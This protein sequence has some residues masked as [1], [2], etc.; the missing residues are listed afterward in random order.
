MVHMCG[1]FFHYTFIKVFT[2]SSHFYHHKCD[3]ICCCLQIPYASNTVGYILICSVN[4]QN[5]TRIIITFYDCLR[6]IYAH[7]QRMRG[8]RMKKEDPC[9]CNVSIILNRKT[10][11]PTRAECGVWCIFCFFPIQFKKTTQALFEQT[12]C[13]RKCIWLYVCIC[14]RFFSNMAK[15][16]ILNMCVYMV[17]M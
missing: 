7:H 12:I 8:A 4:I 3:E 1:F 9:L 11:L 5:Y 10:I 17:I 2:H 16:Y 14:A 6:R 15:H 13:A